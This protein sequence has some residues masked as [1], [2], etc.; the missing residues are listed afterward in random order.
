MGGRD[1]RTCTRR[2]RA[3]TSSRP[4]TR[5]RGRRNRTSGEGPGVRHVGRP[6]HR[7]AS[8]RARRAALLFLLRG[9]PHEVPRRSGAVPRSGGR[10]Q[11]GAG[12]GGHGLHLPDAPRDPAGRAGVVPDLR[13]GAGAGSGQPGGGAEPRA[14]RHDAPVLDRACARGAGRRA[15]DGRAPDRP[16][17]DR[18]APDLELAAARACHPGRAVG[19]MAVLRPRLAVARHPQPQHVHPDRD[20]DRGRVA[21]QHRGDARARSIPGRLPEPRRRGAGLFRGRRGH[22]RAGA[23]RAGARAAGPR[24]DERRHPGAPRPRAEDRPPHPAGRDRGGGSARRGACRRPAARAPRREGPGR[25]R[26][27]RGAQRRR[28]V[29]WSPAN[30]CR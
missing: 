15:R 25:R 9:L 14:H 4:R 13:H 16:R 19:R 6:A 27:R 30:R 29:R 23:S 8:G 24:G 17:P 12:S 5:R 11:G 18:P 28:R 20:R 10:R 7:E 3:R 2:A 22:H 21:L 1:G 26:G